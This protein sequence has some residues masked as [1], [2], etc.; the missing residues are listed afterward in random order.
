M[1]NSGWVNDSIFRRNS[2]AAEALLAAVIVRKDSMGRLV[3]WFRSGIAWASFYFLRICERL[4]PTSLLSLLLRP[5]AALI[6]LIH[7]PERKLPYCWRRFPSSWHPSRPRYFLRQS[8]GLYHA[9][10][11]YAWPDRLATSRWRKRCRIEG[12]ANLDRLRKE[13]RPV[14]LTSVHFGPFEILPYWLRAHGIPVTMIR[15]LPPAE[16]LQKL[17]SY[18]YSLSPPAN[19]PVFMLAKEITPLPRFAHVSDFLGPGD[20]LLVMADVER[21][22]QFHVPF[23]DRNV[24]LATGAIRL[25]AMANAE[26]IPC[27]IREIGA[28]KFVLH[29]FKPVPQSYLGR[30]PDLQA[31]GTHL[32]SEVSQVIAKHPEQ[33]RPR[34]LSAMS[35][36]DGNAEPDFSPLD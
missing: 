31:I 7:A 20:R 24:R 1:V 6:D 15:G 3:I 14:V 11:V 9:Q 26:L 28:W 30:S 18:Q 34:L 17:T 29:F 4:L 25:A 21:G 22:P 16:Y 35:P 10:L 8:L 13:D 36:L 23:Q 12:K 32:L 27:V 19:V 5:P 33:C 2:Q